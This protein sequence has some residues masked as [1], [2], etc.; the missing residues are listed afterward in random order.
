MGT[1]APH[2]LAALFALLL[3]PLLASSSPAGTCWNVSPANASYYAAEASVAYTIASIQLCF[4]DDSY[5]NITWSLY[6]AA[7]GFRPQLLNPAT[8]VG[9]YF[10]EAP[11]SI[12]FSYYKDAS[13]S[14]V[15]SFCCD[16][17]PDIM[18]RFS[19]KY[20]FEASP[21]LAAPTLLA[22]TPD[23]VPRASP[24]DAVPRP[25]QWGDLDMVHPMACNTTGGCAGAFS[26]VVPNPYE[27]GNVSYSVR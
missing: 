4:I 25:Y 16:L 3:L 14:Q 22:I 24:Y 19:G 10:F 27:G 17:C 12:V 6:A 8:A 7:K 20:G 26:G 11:Q 18:Y 13:C 1:T 5:H 21:S 9:I 23:S 2:A 15:H